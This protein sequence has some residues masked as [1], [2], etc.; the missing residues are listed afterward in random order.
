MFE[1]IVFLKI[2][3]FEIKDPEPLVFRD[4]NA[5]KEYVRIIDVELMKMFWL[6]IEGYNHLGGE[7]HIQRT[8]PHRYP[9]RYMKMMHIKKT[10]N[11]VIFHETNMGTIKFDTV[12]N[13]DDQ[14]C[15]VHNIKYSWRNQAFYFS[16]MF[17]KDVNKYIFRCYDHY[18][19]IIEYKIDSKW[20][21]D[22]K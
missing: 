21:S 1:E 19:N 9:K 6:A 3:D 10:L 22:K 13:E 12:I 7:F 17:I 18:S 4:Y 20:F 16:I 15:V 5:T 11:Q 14:Q 2:M 8:K